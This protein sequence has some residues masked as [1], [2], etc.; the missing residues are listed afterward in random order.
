[1]KILYFINKITNSGGMERIIIDKMNFLAQQNNYTLFLAYYGTKDDVSFYLLDK[2]IKKM[3]IPINADSLSFIN[4]SINTIRLVR[5]IRSTI[6]QCKPDIIINANTI[7]VSW[8]LPFMKRKI[9]KIIELH[10]S[11]D[12]I[13]QMNTELYKSRIKGKI[14]DLLRKTIYPLYHKMVVLT[15]TDKIA[16]NFNNISVIPN[17]TSL[18]FST[19]SS[20]TYPKA[21]CVGR[22]EIQKDIPILLK[23]WKIVLK[24]EPQWTLDIWGE[25]S[26]KEQLQNEISTLGLQNSV[27]L[28][29][30][31]Q[32]IQ[33]EYLNSSLFIL[34]SLYEGF[35]LVLIEAMKAG[36]PCIGFDIT[37]NN[38]IICNGKNGFI[39]KER[40]PQALAKTILQIISHPKTLPDLGHNAYQKSLLFDKERIMLLWMQLFNTLSNKQ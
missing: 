9:P 31:S 19:Q 7:L 39:V 35:P 33:N 11:Y 34:P 6:I 24:H 36:L 28:K 2:K 4:K 13:K 14:L 22:L 38:E 32:T 21:I 25:G 5:I 16:W 40:T 12:G 17:F 23:A 3:P 30:T 26:L 15:E 1:M 29:G 10:F 27:T 37:G 8:I 18:E 20:L